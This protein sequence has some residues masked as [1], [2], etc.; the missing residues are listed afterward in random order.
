MQ[1]TFWTVS[2]ARLPSWY[3]RRFP[4]RIWCYATTG[5]ESAAPRA[6]PINILAKCRED[7]DRSLEEEGIYGEKVRTCEGRFLLVV[8]SQVESE[9]DSTSTSIRPT[10]WDSV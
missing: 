4:K 9:R 5:M 6:W 2:T 7:V 8:L 10:T 1:P 3:S